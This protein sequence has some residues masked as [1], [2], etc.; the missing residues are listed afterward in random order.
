MRLHTM[1]KSS[2]TVAAVVAIYAL[3]SLGCFAA[4]L[5]S[6]TEKTGAPPVA[7]DTDYDDVY[8]WRVADRIG[9]YGSG[10]KYYLFLPSSAE[11]S[12]VKLVYTG[13]LGYYDTDTGETIKANTPFI[14]DCTNGQV[15]IYEK[16]ASGGF[17]RYTLHVMKSASLSAVYFNLDEGERTLMKI[18]SDKEF[19]GTGDMKMVLPGGE[20]IYNDRITRLK[21]HG[22][23]SY[24]ASGKLNTKNSYNM[25]TGKKVEL[26]DGAGKSRKWALLRI[27]VH[28]GYDPTG[29]SYL[30]AFNSYNALA[31]RDYFNICARYTDVYIGGEYRGVY[32]LTERMDING[33]IE[34]T[35]LEKNTLYDSSATKRVTSSS[36]R[37]DPAIIAGIESYSYCSDASL[38]AGTTDI[39]GGYVLE[40]MCGTYGEC[41]FKTKE[42]M[43]VNI[44]SPACATREQVQYIAEYVQ[45]FENAIFAKSGRNQSG[46]HYSD[47]ADM[48]SYA[49]Q[50]LIYSYYLNWEIYRTSTYMFK[51][52]DGTKY[53]KLTF[54]PVWDFESGSSVMYDKTLFGTTFAYTE[55]Q[56]YIWNQQ[57]WQK[58]EFMTLI[59]DINENRLRPVLEQLLGEGGEDIHSMNALIDEISAA[60]Y[61]NWIRWSQPDDYDT[62]AAQ[63][64]EAVKARFDHWYEILWNPDRY[65]LGVEINSSLDADDSLV[66][67]ADSRGA[68]TSCQWYKMS[69]D[70]RR[71]VRISGATDSVFKPSEDG[72][73]YCTVSGANNAYWSDASG[74]V[75]QNKMIPMTSAPIDSAAAY[76]VLLLPATGDDIADKTETQAV[77]AAEETEASVTTAAQAAEESVL[78]ADKIPIASSGSSG[79][80]ATDTVSIFATVIVVFISVASAAALGRK[81]PRNKYDA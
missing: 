46:I 43:Y 37:N 50:I 40:I 48:E 38:A 55:Q 3:L 63:M 32:I 4:S 70:M 78:S 7:A 26:I 39:T 35:D 29:L 80:S 6:V 44:K 13:S 69:G 65:L 22:L 79:L 15:Y 24:E 71:A 59:S 12:E 27:R 17:N 16:N 51:D 74:I 2:L 45:Q 72:V 28:G 75:F 52:T 77:I 33:S 73:Y 42:G 23:T 8:G 21:G 76:S 61:M 67:K 68:I 19:V 81:S 18:N 53:D 49:L 41:G 66:L 14:L 64:L 62:R 56:Q 30:L 9:L 57:L 1:I 20:C 54:G 10:G 31:G 58:G 47:Y 60:Q 5:P 34:I 11:L 36:S 25:N